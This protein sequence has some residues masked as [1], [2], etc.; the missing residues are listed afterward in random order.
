MTKYATIVAD[1]PWR[2]SATGE[3]VKGRMKGRGGGAE[4]HYETLTMD[5]IAALPVASL[6]A[7]QA[8]LYLWV[9]NPK[10]FAGPI[11]IVK[12]WGFTYMTTLTW[13]KTGAP[14]LGFYFRGMTEHVLFATRG[15]LGIE[16]ARR[17]TNVITAPRGRH[18]AK[19]TEFYEKVERVSPAPRLE[20][21]ARAPRPGWHVWGNEVE[22][23]VD[24]VTGVAA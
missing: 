24:L 14:G 21:F 3:R 20:L 5:E 11:E 13:V 18:S 9:T 19:P 4:R 17:E 15:G 6:A 2:Y 12:A 23:D 10:M 7:D 1:P 16:P 22:S 8:H